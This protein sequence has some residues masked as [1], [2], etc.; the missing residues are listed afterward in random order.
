MIFSDE[1]LRA[2]L[3]EMKN[4]NRHGDPYH[5]PEDHHFGKLERAVDEFMFQLEQVPPFSWVHLCLDCLSRAIG[6]KPHQ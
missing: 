6:E 1:E 3:A 4:T 2:V 5:W